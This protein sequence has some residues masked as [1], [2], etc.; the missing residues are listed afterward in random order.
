MATTC[1]T[2]LY[3]FNAV[4]P[5]E[6]S[7][8]L[9]QTLLIL[10]QRDDGW[11]QCYNESLHQSGLV[12]TNYLKITPSSSSPRTPSPRIPSSPRNVS[13]PSSSPRVNHHQTAAT[14]QQ[15]S[16]VPNLK[17]SVFVN[18][19]NNSASA[20]VSA[21]SGD[22][23]SNSTIVKGARSGSV[24]ALQK[25]LME[26]L[27][28]NRLNNNSN[29]NNSNSNSSN[30]SSSMSNVARP[31]ATP[32]S[33]M[34]SASSSST[35]AASSSTNNNQLLN[36][37]GV[38]RVSPRANNTDDSAQVNPHRKPVPTIPKISLKPTITTAT[39]LTTVASNDR[40]HIEPPL[41]NSAANRTIHFALE[42]QQLESSNMITLKKKQVKRNQLRHEI[43]TTEK[44]Y[45]KGLIILRDKFS[46]PI[47]EQGLMSDV[48]Y[49]K[50][51][52]S[53]LCIITN[54]NTQFLQYLERIL[55]DTSSMVIDMDQFKLMATPRAR[56]N[57]NNYKSQS[58]QLAKLL[59]QYAHSFKL[60]SDYI[61][62][63][64]SIA[65]ALREEL[66]TNT[67]LASFLQKQ[68]NH[69][70]NSGERAGAILDYA[71]TPVQRLPRYRLLFDELLQNTEVDHESYQMLQ[72]ACQ[73]IRQIA[74][75]C[76]EKGKDPDQQKTLLHVANRLNNRD[77]VQPNR[78]VLIS[79]VDQTIVRYMKKDVACECDLFVASDSFVIF[80]K[81]D[82]PLPSSGGLIG[83]KVTSTKPDEQSI[84]Q[85]LKDK[86]GSIESVGISKSYVNLEICILVIEVKYSDKSRK[87]DIHCLYC[88]SM[89]SLRSIEST[90]R[91][92][93]A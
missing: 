21:T 35:L 79:L 1:A 91:K 41:D 8:K 38:S 28:L 16:T 67:K 84:T 30:N 93:V 23:S 58:T 19:N 25:R 27:E 73:F 13:S 10:V 4:E 29:I 45:V 26:S 89:D 52:P 12:P 18:N 17:P 56:S 33:P 81:Q 57:S 39:T 7:I 72:Q 15:P 69:L 22:G 44:S 20:S 24:M 5:D 75:F 77:F 76:N 49:N 92:I 71:I 60:Y 3:D 9:G 32:P 14:Q 64:P 59:L 50:V 63:Y 66:A 36:R 6:L 82:Q 74:E 78:K 43:L 86:N 42:K 51:F 70:L 53:E 40:A 54:V 48:A 47:K 55:S 88:T 31:F 11:C 2:A 80:L 90:I 65:G 37:A 87:A 83:K 68:K 85:L 34:S 61:N 46:K 62:K